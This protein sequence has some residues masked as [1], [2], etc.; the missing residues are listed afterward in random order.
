M[1]RLII[2][3]L[4]LARLTCE[5][6]PVKIPFIIEPRVHTGIM[7][8]FYKALNYLA[9]DDIYAF[10][11]SVSFPTFGKSYWDKLYNYPRTGIGY[12]YWNLGN[13]EVLGSANTIYSFI[14]IPFYKWKNIVQFNYQISLGGAYL[15]KIFDVNHNHLDRAIG[16]HTN[17]YFR[18]GIDGKIKLTS[19]TEL[20]LET[21]ITHFSNGKTKSPNYGINAG[22]FSVGLNYLF[23]N[24][25]DM[26]NKPEIPQ[27][28]K[29]YTHSF[30][31]S[32]GSKVYDNLLGK[33]YLVS[34]ASY[35]LERQIDLKRKIGL[36]AD[37]SY[38]GS[39]K[40]ALAKQDGTP[41]TDFV[42]LIRVGLHAS[43][44]VRYKQVVGGIQL[45]HYLYSKY[46]VLTPF[47]SKLS[48]KYLITN[49]IF[50]SIALKSHMG[51]ADCLE[52]GAGYCW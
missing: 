48:I 5:A 3:V 15:S 35:N 1:N 13:N 22:T 43:Y 41:E 36:G 20:I 6:Q 32:A 34:S 16:S 26:I 25:S 2:V 39:I 45:G 31:Y 9:K 33:K 51:K 12:S 8:P 23:N 11:L 7:F 40:E 10:D 18:L 29:K 42:K 37:L 30:I 4:L 49:N 21:G 44:A 17:I 27:F 46:I 14:N 28:E 52:F 50:G 24:S 19:H 47:Y 38:D